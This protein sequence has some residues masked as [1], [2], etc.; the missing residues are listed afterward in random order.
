MDSEPNLVQLRRLAR[1][2][3]QLIV[4]SPD[5]QGLFALVFPDNAGKGTDPR[6]KRAAERA[7][8][9][10]VGMTLTGIAELLDPS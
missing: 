10:G 5:D 3:K 1:D 9:D 4:Q 7:F 2:R 8:A 6:G